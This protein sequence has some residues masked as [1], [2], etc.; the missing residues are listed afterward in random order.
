[1]GPAVRQR[2]G[3]RLGSSNERAAQQQDAADEAWLEWSFAADLGVGRTKR[4]EAPLTRI[5]QFGL[6][7]LDAINALAKSGHYAQVLTVLYAAIDTMAWSSRKDGDVTRQDFIGW[8]D[9]YMDPQRSLPC[10]PEDLYAARCGVL[11]SGAAGSRLSRE[12]K[13]VELWYVTAA[14]STADLESFMKKKG[15]NAKVVS[16][17]NLV[18]AFGAGVLAYAEDLAQDQKRQA[19]VEKRIG[20]WL[21]FIP[22][23][24]VAAEA[25]K[26]K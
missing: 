7:T 18:A 16:A 11:H 5:E 8:V 26:K 22:S 2:P 3:S 23:A 15:V 17:T 6:T 10:T 19:E 12:G 14:T 13:A 1:V 21:T 25:A 4:A 20:Q 9:K 24:A